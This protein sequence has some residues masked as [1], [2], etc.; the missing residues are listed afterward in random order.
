[1]ASTLSVTENT[2]VKRL[3]LRVLVLVPRRM[4]SRTRLTLGQSQHA[5]PGA[6]RAQSP[7]SSL[8]P[9]GVT[10]AAVTMRTMGTALL[11]PPLRPPAPEP[12]PPAG[13][14]AKLSF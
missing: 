12:Q 2:A 11:P 13:S 3:W 1:M 14:A 9:V 8:R 4:I 6:A 5:E 7:L 10:S